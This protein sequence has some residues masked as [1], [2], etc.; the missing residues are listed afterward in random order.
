MKEMENCKFERIETEITQKYRI[1]YRFVRIS[2]S[3]LFPYTY[4]S[5]HSA[6]WGYTGTPEL[7]YGLFFS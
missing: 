5:M 7:G 1:F 6:V 4:K 2:R 3:F